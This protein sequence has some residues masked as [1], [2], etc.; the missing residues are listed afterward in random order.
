MKT[1]IYTTDGDWISTPAPYEKVRS[2]LL[3]NQRPYIE[4]PGYNGNDYLIQI[5][6]ITCIEGKLPGNE[7]EK[8]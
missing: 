3:D 6:Q 8:K 4:V 1:T 2:L 5:S 7:E